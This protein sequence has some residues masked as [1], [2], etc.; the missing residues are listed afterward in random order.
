M[1]NSELLLY[2]QVAAWPFTP[3]Y[4]QLRG[5]VQKTFSS[6]LSTCGDNGLVPDP[7]GLKETWSFLSAHAQGEGRVW[8][9]ME[10]INHFSGMAPDQLQPRAELCV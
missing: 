5:D 9:K 7:G 2:Q 1:L 4:F 8:R 10:D 6:R 3:Q